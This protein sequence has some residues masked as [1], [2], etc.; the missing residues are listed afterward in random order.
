MTRKSASSCQLT[1]EVSG[2][3]MGSRCVCRA[4][5]LRTNFYEL[6]PRTYPPDI[7]VILRQRLFPN[8][9][10]Y[11]PNS[12]YRTRSWISRP[13]TPF[14]FSPA[15]PVHLVSASAKTPSPS[16]K[17]DCERDLFLGFLVDEIDNRQMKDDEMAILWRSCQPSLFVSCGLYSNCEVTA[18]GI[19]ETWTLLL[20]GKLRNV[21]FRI[22]GALVSH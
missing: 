17:T 5:R 11:G 15:K 2:K 16:Q 10:V 6:H 20:K 22:N 19:R 13:A 7:V 14:F 18:A 8:R 9:D 12:S 3:E 4:A 21:Y 1:D